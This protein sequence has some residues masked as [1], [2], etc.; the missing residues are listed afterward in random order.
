MSNPSAAVRAEAAQAVARVMGGKTLDDALAACDVSALTAQNKSLLMAMAYGVVR[1]HTV[2]ATLAAKMM[3]KP[4]QNQ[5]AVH[6]LLLCGLHQLRSMRMP[7]HAAVAETVNA[8]GLLDAHWARGMTNAVMRRYQRERRELEDGLPTDPVVR[9]SHPEWLV[10]AIRADWPRVW[11]RVLLENNE[12]GP[13]TLR[14]NRRVGVPQEYLLRLPA[15]GLAGHVVPGAP[16]AIALEEA[17]PVEQL[18]GFADGA[19]SIQDASA[20]LAADLLVGA[21]LGATAGAATPRLRILDACAAPGGKTA[22]LLERGDCEVT[23]LDVDANRLKRVQETLTRLKLSAT[24]KQ[25]DARMPSGWWDDKPFDR[26]LIDAP[27]SGTGV[28]RRHPDIKFLRR[29]TDIARMAHV[30]LE[31]LHALFPLLAPK[32]VLVYAVCSVL[33]A[34]GADVVQRFL[35]KETRARAVPIDASWGEPQGPGRRLPP[36]GDFD[37]F[38]Y[39]KIAMLP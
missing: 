29:R 13:L 23:A 37:G 3:D 4:L 12:P 28:I 17:V 38:F 36:G 2:L 30:Q 19:V 33:S 39:A 14:V 35:E 15:A 11:K 1:E 25:G 8:V 22:H 5:P 24:L 34:E 7:A 31:L 18:P 6:A 10:D 9:T 32:G 20:Q 26:I 27:C 16:E 21:P